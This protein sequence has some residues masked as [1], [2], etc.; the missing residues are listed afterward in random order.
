MQDNSNKVKVLVEVGM[1]FIGEDLKAWCGKFPLDDDQCRNVLKVGFQAGLNGL[2]S[3]FY[4]AQ[5]MAQ[6][7]AMKPN[8]DL[9][10]LLGRLRPIYVSAMPFTAETIARAHL[11]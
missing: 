2:S 6:V 1:K 7:Y 3:A 11:T 8:D 9:M 5:W 4:A 10:Q